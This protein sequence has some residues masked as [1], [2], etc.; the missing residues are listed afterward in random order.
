MERSGSKRNNEGD[1]GLGGGRAV[2]GIRL[3]PCLAS[4]A[5]DGIPCWSR[6]P[7]RFATSLAFPSLLFLVL[8]I[9]LFFRTTASVAVN[10]GPTD[11]IYCFTWR[12]SYPPSSPCTFGTILRLA[13][14]PGHASMRFAFP[15]IRVSSTRHASPP[16][17]SLVRKSNCLFWYH[18]SVVVG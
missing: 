5:T 3:S 18:D 10:T 13:Y 15:R 12:T 14:R 8:S 9:P 16:H 4:R 17:M 2:L 1:C 7:S 6:S 11:L